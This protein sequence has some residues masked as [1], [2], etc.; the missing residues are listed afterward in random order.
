[1][2]RWDLA[3]ELFLLVVRAAR[4][5]RPAAVLSL[6]LMLLMLPCAA[7]SSRNGT[8]SGFSGDSPSRETG[9]YGSLT[10]T[11]LAG[12]RAVFDV[13]VLLRSID[14]EPAAPAARTGANGDFSF[15]EV[16]EGGY[17]LVV[18]YGNRQYEQRVDLIDT[19]TH[20][21]VDL[22]DNVQPGSSA[23]S[24]AQLSIPAKARRLLQ[25]ARHVFLKGDFAK[26]EKK[27]EEALAA[28][29]NFAEALSLRASL[30]FEQ[31]DVAG[32]LHD[33]DLAIQSDPAYPDGYY[34]K[35][36]ALNGQ[37]HFQDAEQVIA[38]GVH[39]APAAWQFH[40]QMALAL[41][42]EGREQ[43]AL[44]EI[45]QAAA[46]APRGF[47]RLHLVRGMLMVQLGD[48]TGGA[49]ELR[50]FVEQQPQAPMAAEARRV[51]AQVDPQ[52]SGGN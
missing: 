27:L 21:R 9:S 25:D 12:N 3:G 18:E 5:L 8:Y 34:L 29:P 10:G 1:M 33:A 38:A 30:R 13:R 44:E 22:P 47:S 35:A 52:Y 42:G 20:V 31:H 26:G 15:S 36:A 7:Q 43:P 2:A 16:P 6:L 23:V 49:G 19:L 17:V 32:A 50:T 37:G 14:G 11:V 24:A 48:R 41:L 28:A 39:L 51:L 46:N 45:N 4:T 40:F